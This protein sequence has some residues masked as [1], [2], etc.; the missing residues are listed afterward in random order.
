MRED[1]EHAVR[2]G[3]RECTILLKREGWQLGR[4]QLTPNSRGQLQLRSKLPERLQDGRAATPAHRARKAGDAWTMDFAPTSFGLGGKFRV[5]TV[6]DVPSRA[7][8]LAT[9]VGKQSSERNTCRGP[10][11]A[12]RRHVPEYS[13]STTQRVHGPA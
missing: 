2:Y 10:S 6:V 5:L 9:E 11:I 13:S 1:R 8:L 7:R 4:S 12:C 3:S